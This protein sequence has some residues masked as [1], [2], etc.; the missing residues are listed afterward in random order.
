MAT[1]GEFETV[2]EPLA[3]TEERGHVSTIWKAQKRGGEAGRWLRR[4]VLRAAPPQARAES[5]EAPLD[6]DPKLDFLQGIKQLREA[7]TQGGRCLAPVHDCGI[8]EAEA[9]YAT[10]YY[11]RDTLR[12]FIEHLG[13]ADSAALRHVVHSIV[14]ACLALKRSRGYSHGNLKTSN[15]FLGGQ[16]KR[17]L[18]QTPLLLAD[19][20]PAALGHLAQLDLADQRAVRELLAETME[21]Q[22]LRAL[23]ELILQLVERRL[24]KSDQY[25]YPL[26]ASQRWRALGREGK[27]WLELCNKLLDPRLTLQAINL[28]TL[29]EEFR[30]SVLA[31][32]LPLI[33]GVA[34]GVLVL[35]GIGFL[36]AK[37]HEARVEEQF[38]TALQ[39]TKDAVNST[40][41]VGAQHQV[42]VALS[43]KPRDQEAR[44]LRDQILPRVDAE[45]G[46][47]LGRAR[48]ELGLKHLETASNWVSRAL[49]LKPAGPEATELQAKVEKAYSDY[50]TALAAA[51]AALREEKW[52]EAEQ[53][54]KQALNLK[55][56]G[57]EALDL[58]KRIQQDRDKKFKEARTAA[59]NALDARDYERAIGQATVALNAKPGDQEA[60]SL[61]GQAQGKK[62]FQQQLDTAMA[63]GEQDLDTGHYP[64]AIKKFGDARGLAKEL[65]DPQRENQADDSTKYARFLDQ[66][67]QA[68]KGGSVSKATRALEEAIKIRDTPKVRKW[69]ASLKE[70]SPPPVEPKPPPPADFTAQLDQ[71]RQSL[72]N[73]LYPQADGRFM[74]ILQANPRDT[75][76]VQSARAGT[77]FARLMGKALN[78]RTGG[79]YAQAAKLYGWAM[80]N[81]WRDKR[82]TDGHELCQ[83]MT[84][85]AA[86]LKESELPSAFQEA[87]NRFFKAKLIDIQDTNAAGGLTLAR[88]VLTGDADYKAGRF[89]EAWT[90]YNRASVSKLYGMYATNRLQMAEQRRK[91]EDLF[92]NKDYTK[93]IPPFENADR[94]EA[95]LTLET[96]DADLRAD[97]RIKVARYHI[98]C[99]QAQSSLAQTKFPEA[100]ESAKA[101]A[102]IAGN[103]LSKGEVQLAND[104][105]VKIATNACHAAISKRDPASA[106]GWRKQA[107]KFGA[108][109]PVLDHL[110]NLIG[111]IEVLVAGPS[112]TNLF[113]IEFVWI[114]GLRG[115]G[116]YVAETELSHEQFRKV[117]KEMGM[118]R[119]GTT[120]YQAI[121]NSSSPEHQNQYGGTDDNSVMMLRHRQA[122]EL[123]KGLNERHKALK[124]YPGG[125]F[126]L[127]RVD[128]F[129]R[130]ATKDENLRTNLGST[131]TTLRLN[132]VVKG[133]LTNKNTYWTAFGQTVGKPREVRA[134]APNDFGLF[135]VIGNAWEWSDE[136]GYAIGLSY[137]S[138][139]Y[140]HSKQIKASFGFDNN[141]GDTVSM[142][143][144]FVLTP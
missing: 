124:K 59:H 68:R 117:Y 110:N 141:T 28:E 104:L 43:L 51:G 20:Y 26:A 33:V 136:D 34:A 39:A 44:R 139:G 7:Q 131:N 78:C 36:V 27:R 96:L 134:G 61:L 94:L 24:I 35:A 108:P 4:Q 106:D 2:G 73:A 126:Q 83:A 50:R 121:L 115:R 22:D 21:A 85:A 60:Q 40:N 144:M 77:N 92:L 69:L 122:K 118:E 6:R 63:G 84:N 54:I 109:K 112:R 100:L 5:A 66:A 31:A 90:N 120:R 74:A 125:D 53:Q 116:A 138:D 130:F 142:R 143:L 65:G 137:M 56:G 18:G 88:N 55:P 91:G 82:T 103:S 135:N 86:A 19:P 3:T 29:E 72:T 111:R 48:D 58:E 9:W 89:A 81:Q 127:P 37:R 32:K 46:L 133:F 128:D 14:T 76:T 67:D 80:T 41:L 129:L 64:D 105:A 71:A 113:G 52:P 57:A 38:Q 119:D 102:L 17:W 99:D 79:D 45:Y 8:T 123:V 101:A 16:K 114:A 97:K 70:P 98:N 25:D 23:G 42:T 87:S 47:D 30:P 140:A 62:S 10:D 12:A 93:A 75:E 13:G 1:F 107:E 49:G 132:V 15:V 11:P 95:R